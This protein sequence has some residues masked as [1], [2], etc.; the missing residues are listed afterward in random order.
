MLLAPAPSRAALPQDGS[1]RTARSLRW[2]LGVGGRGFSLLHP[3]S[4]PLW[5]GCG[6]RQQAWHRPSWPCSLEAI[7]CLAAGLVLSFPSPLPISFHFLSGS[8]RAPPVLR[9]PGA[10]PAPPSPPGA[11]AGDVLRA[12]GGCGNGWDELR[13]KGW[14]FFF[15]WGNRQLGFENPTQLFASKSVCAIKGGRGG[16]L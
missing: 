12:G 7:P 11:R 13:R 4:Q 10:A 14:L 8:R 16:K 5:D 2:E 6:A 3:K 9:A 15:R 1:R